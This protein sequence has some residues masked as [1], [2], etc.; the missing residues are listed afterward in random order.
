MITS[1]FLIA[2]FILGTFVGSA[3]EDKEKPSSIQWIALTLIA[4]FWPFLIYVYGKR[5]K[6][7]K[8]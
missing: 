7:G 6:D 4:M 3:I 2:V 1:Y 8:L 5:W